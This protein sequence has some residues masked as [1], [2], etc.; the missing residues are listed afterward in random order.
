VVAIA[1]LATG[2]GWWASRRRQRTR[3]RRR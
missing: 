3:G 1:L 2:A